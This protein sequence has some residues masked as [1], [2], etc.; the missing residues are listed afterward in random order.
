MER[1]DRVREIQVEALEEV[2]AAS[3][4]TEFDSDDVADLC[5]LAA[6]ITARDNLSASG[7]RE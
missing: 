4:T 6:Q 3:M 7:S 2:Y 1:N 5:A